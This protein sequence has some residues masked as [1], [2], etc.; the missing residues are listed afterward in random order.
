MTSPNPYSYAMQAGDTLFLSGLVSRN[1]RDNTVVTGDVTTQTRVIMDNAGELLKTAGMTYENVVSC[2]V[3]LPQTASFQEMNA[4]YRSYFSA[5]PPARATVQAALAGSEYAVEITMIASS[6]PREAINS[7]T[8]NPNLSGAIRA[9]GRLY[10]SG[11]LGNT[12]ENAGDVTAQTRETLARVREILGAA[13]FTP[14]DIADALVYLT[15]LKDYGAMN[16][17]YREFFG[18]SFPA[19]T[20]VRS[21]LVA[22]G[23]VVEIMFTAV[24]QQP[25]TAGR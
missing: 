23:G 10:L 7:G 25:R 4:A 20:T 14:A 24:K 12:P 3:F 19:R 6:A 15:D 11:V 2:R 13:G 21:G 18:A 9:G 5:A 17:V 22:P 8:P 16:P 1:G